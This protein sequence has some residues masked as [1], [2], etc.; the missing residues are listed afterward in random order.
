MLT[1]SEKKIVIWWTYRFN[2][3]VNSNSLFIV[4]YALWLISELRNVIWHVRSQRQCSLPATQRKWTR[5]ALTPDILDLLT[6]EE[7]KAVLI[8]MVKYMMRWFTCRC[9]IFYGVIR[10]HRAAVDRT[11][12]VAAAAT[13]DRTWPSEC[14]RNTTY[15]CSSDLTS[16]RWTD[17]S[18]TTT[19][20]SFYSVLCLCVVFVRTVGLII[21]WNLSW[22]CRLR[23]AGAPLVGISG[24]RQT[25]AGLTS[26]TGA[27]PTFGTPWY[28]YM[29]PP[30][31]RLGNLNPRLHYSRASGT[32][33]GLLLAALST[34]ASN[35]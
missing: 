2:R 31:V 14:W 20:R 9:W 18:T 28:L 35:N 26:L 5:L 22:Y 19:T 24:R 13:S 15:L 29:C 32:K 11:R 4:L 25:A 16:A 30:A 23:F 12:F 33:L 27:P 8:L 21:G 7:W 34:L 1:T 6:P 10:C 3:W 17:T